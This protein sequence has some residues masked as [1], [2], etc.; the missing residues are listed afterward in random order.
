MR[1]VLPLYLDEFCVSSL[2]GVTPAQPASMASAA[3]SAIGRN[4]RPLMVGME[5]LRD[6]DGGRTGLK[7]ESTPAPPPRPPRAPCRAHPG[8]EDS[9]ARIGVRVPRADAR[10]H[11]QSG[12]RRQPR[13]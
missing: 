2:I 4:A 9:R 11:L 5:V 6:E 7:S 8:T 13:E 3:A 10:I 1:T 12:R